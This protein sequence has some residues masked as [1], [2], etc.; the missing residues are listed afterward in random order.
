MDI[1]AGEYGYEPFYF[2]RML[3]Y[4]SVDVLQADATRCGGVTGFAQAGTLCLARCMPLSA[5]TAPSIHAH[6]SCAVQQVR[7]LEYFHDHIRIE[8]IC[9]DGV[10]EPIEGKLRPDPERPGMGLSLRREE[11]KK[12]AAI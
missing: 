10:L 6:L 9:F 8:R 1:A 5:H 4:E 7:H 3:E 11:M 12:Y 2:R